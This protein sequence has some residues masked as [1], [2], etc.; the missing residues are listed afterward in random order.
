MDFDKRAKDWDKD[1]QK[2]QRAEILA[3]E[4]IKYFSSR[5][6][7][8]VFEF[9]CGTGLIS[10]FLRDNFK[11]FTLADNSAGMIEVVNEKIK[12][13]GLK[14]MVALHIDLTHQIPE[15][16][17]QDLIFAFMSLHHVLDLDE[18]FDAFYKL[19]KPGGYLCI[20]DLDEE[21]GSFHYK[22]PEF[23]GHYGF[24]R[25]KIETLY[26]KHGFDVEHYR[27]FY[28]IIKQVENTCKDYPLFMAV[29]KKVG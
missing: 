19:L 16:Q 1:Q 14:N 7:E 15:I 12:N 20:A 9:G 25:N 28:T 4:I 5:P 29:G 2:V 3:A 18:I 8:H 24:S 10:Y 26:K 27:I 11:H 21:D 22:H 6:F 23:K 13:E 17:K